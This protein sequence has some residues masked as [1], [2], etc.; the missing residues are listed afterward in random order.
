MTIKE[1]VLAELNFVRQDQLPELLEFVRHLNQQPPKVQPSATSLAS[2]AV[3]A[4][5]WLTP[6]EDAAWQNL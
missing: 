2:E 1:Q 6:E 4:L 5:D 3:L